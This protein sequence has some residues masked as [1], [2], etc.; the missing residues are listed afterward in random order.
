MAHLSP[1]AIFSPSIAR[2]QLAASKDWNYIDN[3]LSKRFNGRSVPAYERNPDTLKTLLT[4][5]AANE[6]ADEDRDL[7]SNV[8]AKAL[9]N[10]Q[11]QQ[12]T[13]AHGDI[14]QGLEDNLSREGHLS[15]DALAAASV[16]LN[17]PRAD[18]VAL[19]QKILD[20][21]AASFDLEQASDRVEILRRHLEGE[22]EEVDKLVEELRGDSFQPN[23][24][25]SSQ[26]QDYQ[27]KIKMLTAK[28]P[29]LKDRAAALTATASMPK[30]MVQ[31]VRN[32]EHKYTEIM[33]TVKELETKVK[34]YH[35]LPHDVDLARLELETLRVE[36]NDLTKE[37][38]AMFESLV[39]R[40]SPKKFR[41]RR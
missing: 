3:W 11:D 23:A 20:L 6:S 8:E 21:Q 4:L 32:E 35:G 13:E 29:E 14:L 27:R 24:E 41:S 18:I 15:L 33:G 37:R 31:D 9:A 19:A 10:L 1:S 26:T 28:L 17:Q 12:A 39:E 2:Q 38:D 34:S 36:L 7:L 16:A 5:A 40:E 25:L 22:V 30:P